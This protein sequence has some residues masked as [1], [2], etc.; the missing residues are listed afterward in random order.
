MVRLVR[1]C[2]PLLIVAML[3][4]A[5]CG[6]GGGTPSERPSYEEEAAAEINEQNMLAELDRIEGSLAE[7]IAA[8]GP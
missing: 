3:Y 4:T 1:L 8:E 7:E 6:K 5:G 2:V